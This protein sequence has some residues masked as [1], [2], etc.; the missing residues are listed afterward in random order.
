M[1][2]V[3][4]V[5]YEIG[6]L[7]VLTRELT[8]VGS[9]GFGEHHRLTG[10]IRGRPK[11][12]NTAPACVNLYKCALSDEFLSNRQQAGVSC[13]SFECIIESH[14]FDFRYS[15]YTCRST[16]LPKIFGR[17]YLILHLLVLSFLYRV[18]DQFS[19]SNRFVTSCHSLFLF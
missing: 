7:S 19:N 14:G 18:V 6:K 13:F 1:K 11:F 2:L 16:S 12:P 9:L 3:C 5:P 4:T 17:H 8:L 15:V 10:A